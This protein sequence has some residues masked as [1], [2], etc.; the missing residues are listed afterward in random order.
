[1]PAVRT[2]PGFGETLPALLSR[3]LGVSERRALAGI[4]VGVGLLAVAAV[5]L[6]DPLCG[7]S[8]LV[9]RGAP[10]F[11]ALY[12]R[13]LVR[14]VRPRAGEYQRFVARGGGVRA[15]LAVHQLRLPA[16]RGEVGGALPIVAERRK[17]ALARSLPGFR[18]T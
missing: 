17:A 14:P 4:G 9:H 5:L 15:E 2:R 18:L 10:V 7:R 13:G 12:P 3:R 11:N 8:E 1:M 16:Y 6:Y